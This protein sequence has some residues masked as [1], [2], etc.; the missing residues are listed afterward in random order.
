LKLSLVFQNFPRP[1]SPAICAR[2]ISL[3]LVVL[4]PSGCGVQIN[5]LRV[6]TG[7]TAGVAGV[8]PILDS[9]AITE[10]SPTNVAPLSLQ[11]GVV[12]GAY[13]S[14]C[15]LENSTDASTCVWH[16]GSL[17]T[18]YTDAGIDGPCVLT[19]FVKN[20]YG[21]SSPLSSNS[22]LIDRTAPVLASAA[23]GNAS[24]TNSTTFSLSFGAVTFAPYTDYCI[25]ENT[26]S[27]A[28]CAWQSGALPGSY[29][30][31]GAN[32]T[33]VLTVW[34][35][36]SAGNVSNFVQT[37]PVVYDGTV[38]IVTL[39]T[40]SSGSYVNLG[41]QAAVTL[42][43][44]C[45]VN[46]QTIT[47]SGAGA[48]TASCLAGSWSISVDLSAA[49]QGPVTLHADFSNAAGT[50]AAQAAVTLTKD[51]VA[52]TVAIN[53]PA[54]GSTINL[55]NVAAFTLAGTCS[56]NGQTVSVSGSA[57]GTATCNAGNWTMSLNFTGAADGAVSITANLTDAA[58]NLSTPATRGFTKDTIA[59]TVAI[60]SP[61]AGTTINL[62]NVT[63][64]AVSGTCTQNGATVM[65]SGAATGS[66][67][68]A[69]GTWSASLDFST[70]T[71]G[72]VAVNAN[73][74][75]AAGNP[76]VQSTRNFT[77]ATGVPAVAITS[78]AAGA[79]INA[80][81]VGAFT[82]SGTCSAN[83]QNVVLS[84]DASA[85][86]TCTAGAWSANLNF[87]AAPEGAVTLNANLSDSFG[88]PAP[89]SSRS[90]TK[91]T[92][93]PTVAI[94]APAAGAYVNIANQTTFAV[95]G[96]CSENG[97][98]VVLSGAAAATVAC[99]SNAWSASL[100]F[101]TAT[102]GA[103]TL[104][105]NTTDIAGN[106]A[107]QAS[108]SFTKDTVAPTVVLNNP[109]S[110]T[111]IN[112]ATVATFTVSGTC[113]EN[114][115]TVTAHGSNG[116]SGTVAC[117]SNVWSI[118]LDTTAHGEGTTTLTA[119][120]NDAAGNPATP[121][122]VAY[123][124]DTVA[125]S[126]TISSPAAGT[127]ATA[128][129]DTAF[130]V[131]GA[132]SENGK[133]VVLSGVVAATTPCAS[134]AWSINLDVS[135]ATDGVITVNAD[136]ADYAGNPAPTATRSFGKDSNA[137][138]AT[139]LTM[140][141][142]TNATKSASPTAS[143]VG[144]FGADAGATA[145][146]TS[147]TVSVFLNDAACATGN[148]V[149]TLAGAPGSAI[150][151]T[152]SSLAA[153]GDGLKTLYYTIA[154]TYGN[155]TACATTGLS[156]T[157][158]A[159]P[160]V[161]FV[162][163]GT[164]VSEAGAQ[165]GTALTL[166][167]DVCGIATT[168]PVVRSDI[169][170]ISPTN[171]TSGTT[172]V[173]FA[174]TDCS[175][176][177]VPVAN[178]GIANDGVETGDLFFQAK[179]GTIVGGVAAS[180]NQVAQV[181]IIDAAYPGNY[182]FNQ[183]LYTVASGV[184]SASL[185]VQ[186]SG[187]TAAAASVQIA[188]D[189]GSALNGTD[190]TGTT[191]TLN[192]GIGTDEVTVNVPIFTNTY[193]ASFVAKLVSP[194]AGTAVRNLSVS[195]VRIMGA[196]ASACLPAGSPFGGGAGTTGNPYLICTLAQLEQVASNLSKTFKLASDLVADASLVPLGS[197]NGNFDGDEHVV[198]G[199][200]FNGNVNGV[201]FFNR[202]T[203][204]QYVKSLNL[205]NLSVVNGNN[206]S[207]GGLAGVYGNNDSVQAVTN[208]LVSGYVS[209][210]IN[211][212]GIVLGHLYEAY[213]PVTFTA[214]VSHV[215]ALGTAIN[216]FGGVA[217]ILGNESGN[218]TS[219][220]FV[221]LSKDYNGASVIGAVSSTG[222]VVGGENL[223]GTVS[224][225]NLENRGFIKGATLTAGIVGSAQ[226]TSSAVESFSNLTNYGVIQGTTDSGGIIGNFQSGTAST[227][228]AFTNLVN[229]GAV[230][231]TSYTGGVIGQIYFSQ[232]TNT[233]N[234]S[235]GVNYAAVS[236][237]QYVGGIIGQAEATGAITNTTLSIDGSTNSG[238]VSG[239]AYVGGIAG[240]LY[241]HS[242]SAGGS[243]M[244][245]ITNSANT[246]NITVSSGTGYAGGIVGQVTS[247]S[248]GNAALTMT[249]DTSTGG[250]ITCTTGPNCGGLAGY[251][252]LTGNVTS[253]LSGSHVTSSVSSAGS[254]AGGLVGIV[255]LASGTSTFNVSTSDYSGTITGLNQSGGIFGEVA[256]SAGTISV[257]KVNTS[258]SVTNTGNY[259]A[260]I[261]GFFA[262]G[263][264]AVA[265]NLQDLSS[266]MTIIGNT[267]IGG[268]VGA[269]N[270][271][272]ATDSITISDAYATG[273]V[274]GVGGGNSCAGGILGTLYDPSAGYL[275]ANLTRVYSTS[276]V[277]ATASA[278]GLRGC[279]SNG[280]LTLTDDY[281][282]QDT[283]INAGLTA[284]GNQRSSAALL[285]TAT[286]TG[287]DFAT[288]WNAPTATLYPT[289]R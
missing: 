269:I 257:S 89:Q 112:A 84:G 256:N 264:G 263:S 230:T 50:P 74:S 152:T 31:S 114:G 87:T 232:A 37:A 99:A 76:A 221:T 231:G 130:N 28:G 240:Y 119:S 35:R 135:G 192:F 111:F 214:N 122:S 110:G 97:Q 86:V 34:L 157:Y 283:G 272:A 30:V 255:S 88:N 123:N 244:I 81:G 45:S 185:T 189:D 284:D 115:Q 208:V 205:L 69:G 18:S 250:T 274:T 79:T 144:T 164:T 82:V 140:S 229:Y 177:P 248:N 131:A 267:H 287:W 201:G 78:P 149:G 203:L 266:S 52:P 252:T 247:A 73:L 26:S 39:T 6:P 277:T 160:V 136:L 243:N 56:E 236:G 282:L 129:T 126:V 173:V 44:S 216:P 161:S 80:A 85:T 212:S 158:Q 46:G 202:M 260:G 127:V 235:I 61:A 261:V 90:F 215:I 16:S 174:A 137:P 270:G 77:K 198:S 258:G 48:A 145:L 40:P 42:G 151:L 38:P 106:A 54:A 2:L 53:S 153:G 83:G 49:G 253:S 98:N 55:A 226:P 3:A 72:T 210:Q 279:N 36:D 10:S 132:C 8:P 156:Y 5:S 176:K 280:T 147:V 146:G 271:L 13:T 14:Y 242:S 241:F 124:K 58:G 159:N 17:P 29:T 155:S 163:L 179:I 233:A 209:N 207:A 237:N 168:V 199:F 238:S 116:I 165:I 117:A 9:F 268:L 285:T 7:L 33:K 167:R 169:S 162:S 227:T 128:T 104:N 262:L 27:V 64:F 94:T 251:L 213:N 246:A 139:A 108:R 191:Q 15:V 154:D 75:D 188:F 141:T 239:T 23:I 59:P 105:A 66:S 265:T 195:K 217:G 194:S 220:N 109:A 43:G 91:D 143:L 245:G 172:N 166:Q 197:L 222:G 70:A 184:S 65:L 67:V 178:Y 286:Y 204:G 68:C 107:V 25:E 21:I 11:W 12:V 133:N 254:N 92:T 275:T 41:N 125:P 32:G 225:Q 57:A 148:K 182:V 186:R 142:P 190:Y 4:A 96:T 101:S 71:D 93:A 171:Y 100:N 1:I 228:T 103:V 120:L 278:G 19:G 22:V 63:A 281:W 20:T 62:G 273:S 224:Y 259:S 121:S 150:S 218:A 200:N 134:N 196:P 113:S 138:A 276:I 288:V 24:P 95:S 249:A 181:N 223:R 183:P 47:V 211:G 102:D 118:A 180:T 206:G 289:L 60:T 193:N 234:L 170:A 187:S 219:T 51:T 175:P